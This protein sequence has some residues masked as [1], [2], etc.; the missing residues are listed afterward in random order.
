[1]PLYA[2]APGGRSPEPRRTSTVAVV[3]P[4]THLGRPPTPAGPGHGHGHGL[5]RTASNRPEV[6]I[7][8]TGAPATLAS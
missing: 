2:L 8:L 1:M 6:R 4:P 7:G 3:D 5:T